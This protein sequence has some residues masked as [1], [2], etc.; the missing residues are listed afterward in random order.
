MKRISKT[1]FGMSLLLAVTVMATACGPKDNRTP[2]EKVAEAK[3]ILVYDGLDSTMADF[4]LIT[5][6]EDIAGVEI[7]YTAT[8]E[9]GN[10]TEFLKI[11]E[12][13]KTALVKRPEIDQFESGYALA[14]LNATISCEDAQDSKRFVVKVIEGGIEVKATEFNALTSAD[15]DKVVSFRGVVLTIGDGCALVGDDTG[16]VFVYDSSAITDELKVGSY[17]QVDGSVSFYNN[18]AQF[19]YSAT[20]KPT[21]T[22]LEGNPSFTPKTYT[23]ET[24]GGA[25]LDTYYGYTAA[26]DLFGHY[27]SVT[28]LLTVSGKY[29]NITVDGTTKSAGASVCYPGT[30]MKAKLAEYDGTTITIKGYSLY[31]SHDYAY[32]SVEEV[33]QVNLS[34]DDK[35]ANAATALKIVSE[36]AVDFTLPAVGSYGT[37][38]TWTSDNAAIAVGALDTTNNVYPATVTTSDTADISVKLTA[39]ITLDATHKTTKD[40]T[41][42]V[43]KTINYDHAGTAADPYSVAD[44]NKYASTLAVGAT[45]DV[46]VYTKGIISAITT[47]VDTSYGN[48]TFKI[49]DDGAT[50]SQQFLVYRCKWLNN[51]KLTDVEQI[52]VGDEVVIRGKIT[53]YNGTL[54]YAANCYL[55]STS[56]PWTAQ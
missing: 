51:T 1:G 21:L 7:T 19:S 11:S 29:Y 3:N 15:K 40:F 55:H 22:I 26:N 25:E 54:E 39:T 43:L 13:G 45:S 41:V 16:Y 53:N 35:V 24:W 33:T 44:V 56:N 36:T 8:D 2:E 32:F 37:T 34:D 18:A 10:A 30:D 23:L 20:T 50:T 46:E 6:F 48:V 28:G 4:P 49:S 9:G 38:I 52:K 5:S 42:T 31:N 14:L 12:D 47:A 27:V 17:V